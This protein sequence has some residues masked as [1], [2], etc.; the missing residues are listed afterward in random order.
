[1]CPG[2]GDADGD[3]HMAIAC[4]GDD[5][6]DN[7]PNRFPGNP[8]VCDPSH[9]EDCDPRTFGAR[10]R[11]GDG[12]P[13]AMCCNGT[14]AARVCGTDCDDTNVSVNP[15]NMELCN[16]FDDNCNGLV[17]EEPQASMACERSPAGAVVCRDGRCQLANCPPGYHDCDNSTANGCETNTDG[18]PLNCG[19]CG[20][21]CIVAN[22]T[23]ACRS[24]ACVATNCRVG[25]ACGAVCAA[26]NDATLCG[27]MCV[28]CP[29]TANGTA[30]CAGGACGAMC[31]TGFHACSGAC[32]DDTSPLACGASCA[33]CRVPANG[34]A[35]C[36]AGACDF[37]CNAGY[38]K[39]A[40]GCVAGPRLI[41]PLSGS[42]VSALRPQLRWEL[43]SAA[44]GVRVQLCRDRACASVITTFDAVGASGAPAVDLPAGVVFWNARAMSGGTVATAV[45]PTWELVVPRRG[46]AV[47]TAW[48]ALSDFNGDG[49]ADLAVATYDPTTVPANAQVEVHLGTSSGLARAP[50]VT[51][52]PTLAAASFG[53]SM[54]VG[55][56]NGDGFVDLCSTAVR[57]AWPRRPRG[58]CAPRSVCRASRSI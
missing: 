27:A 14:G 9:D 55:D 42:H 44:E 28:R 36:R 57:A 35:V 7:D 26:D 23:P 39:V 2:G 45:S 34:V 24:G 5:C 21:M 3:G 48:G 46:A 29:P 58:S 38:V 15:G 16:G 31:N 18:D 25:H 10:D 54:G 30:T 41:A 33:V 6:D 8:E 56:V 17:D 19:G 20:A 43:P 11:D 12:F 22:G 51:L 53:D 49:L 37:V 47:D 32:V 1:M 50:A 4:G 40:N 52:V 13:D